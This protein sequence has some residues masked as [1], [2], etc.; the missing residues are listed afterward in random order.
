MTDRQ[1]D[2]LTPWAPVG[3]KKA[4]SDCLDTYILVSIRN[5]LAMEMSRENIDHYF[6]LFNLKCPAARN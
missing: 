5:E 2:I 4:K 6:L 3:A 1:T